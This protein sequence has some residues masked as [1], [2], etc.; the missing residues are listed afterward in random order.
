MITFEWDSRDLS[1]WRGRKVDQALTRALRLAGNAALRSVQDESTEGVKK[2]KFLRESDVRKGLVLDF[3][4]GRTEISSLQWTER[5]SG[6]LVPLAKFPFTSTPQGV[7]VNVNRA[8]GARKLIPS[9][10][11][12]TMAN[13]HTGIFVRKG[14]ARLPIKELFS[15]KL[16]DTMQD[17]GLIPSI[18]EVAQVK[19]QKT[20]DRGLERELGKLRRKGDL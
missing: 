18:Y 9:A 4:T 2:R 19:L 13:G 15:S 12:A 11:V 16:S 6:E 3:P 14:K 8:G 10:F 7:R 17:N 5:V 20:F 1:V